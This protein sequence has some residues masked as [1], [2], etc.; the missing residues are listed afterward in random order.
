MTLT[1]KVMEVAKM[2]KI[3]NVAKML[4]LMKVSKKTKVA[5]ATKFVVAFSLII[6][7]FS[8]SLAWAEESEDGLPASE[9]TN[10][11][12]PTQRAD[13]SFIYDTTVASL[14]SQASLYNDRT[15]QI[16]GEV[17]GDRVKGPNG[18]YWITL[19]ETLKND[20]SSISVLM[21]E[22][23]TSQ[24]S[25][26]GRYGVMGTTLQVRGT[27][28]QACD[29]HDGLPDIHA[30]TSSV[31]ESGKDTPDSLNPRDFL[32]GF[33]AIIVG[34]VLMGLFYFARERMR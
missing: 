10:L 3:T 12:D 19:T 32:P 15:V 20:K 27:Y 13:N 4:K 7:L 11:V 18:M 24:I 29:Q 31:M 2:T 6:S 23:Q 34:L 1:A 5:K 30:T 26:Y 8:P 17:I 28:H 33:V 16:M 9:S 21:S 25:H 14:Y 22:E